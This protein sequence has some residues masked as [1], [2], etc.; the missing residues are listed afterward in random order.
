VA[1]V[2]ERLADVGR[3]LGVQVSLRPLEPDVL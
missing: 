3:D 2:G 1:A